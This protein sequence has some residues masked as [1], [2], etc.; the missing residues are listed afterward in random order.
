MIFPFILTKSLVFLFWCSHDTT[1]SRIPDYTSN[2][3]W[4][5]TKVR[6]ALWKC[7][8][9]VFQRKSSCKPNSKATPQFQKLENVFFMEIK[10]PKNWTMTSFHFQGCWLPHCVSDWPVLFS[11]LVILV[12]FRNQQ[13]RILNESGMKYSTLSITGGEGWVKVN[14]NT[15]QG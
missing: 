8:I 11:F 2:R 12:M 10:Q 9:E 5:S 6:A 14:S 15:W 7:S 1:H 13:V 4:G 3:N